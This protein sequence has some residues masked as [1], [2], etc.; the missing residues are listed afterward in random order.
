MLSLFTSWECIKP[1][2]FPLDLIRSRGNTALK[3]VSLGNFSLP[4]SPQR[5]A[6]GAW[7]WVLSLRGDSTQSV[8]HWQS[9]LTIQ[10]RR[11]YDTNVL[12]NPFSI[13]RSQGQSTLEPE[14][15][16]M[17]NEQRRKK[18]KRWTLRILIPLWI[19]LLSTFISRHCSIMKQYPFP[20]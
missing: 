8:A 19:Y 11:K 2:S 6:C 15:E 18:K 16:K 4:N 20:I 17:E 1:F 14:R 13:R 9:V 10:E 5:W 3:E 12:I 7:Q